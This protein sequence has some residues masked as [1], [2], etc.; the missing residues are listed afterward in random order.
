[1]IL[2][3]LGV[4]GCIEAITLM[5]LASAKQ[6]LANGEL[7]NAQ[8]ILKGL[9]DYWPSSEEARLLAANAARRMEA[10]DEAERH[11]KAYEAKYGT[12]EPFLLEKTLLRVQSQG[13]SPEDDQLLRE[14]LKP[15]HSSYW[16]R[17]N[18]VEVFEALTLGYRRV[19]QATATLHCANELLQIEP[20]HV[21]G[22]LARGW[23]LE[24]FTRM[25]EALA[26]YQKAAELDPQNIEARL[27]LGELLL[28]FNRPAEAVGHFEWLRAQRPDN[29]GVGFGLARCR[30]A[31]D[32]LD[33]AARILDELLERHDTHPLLLEARGHV[34]VC[35]NE[36]DEAVRFL[37]EAV[38]R[39]PYLRQANYELSQCLLRQGKTAEAQKYQEQVD[40]ID[41][42]TKRLGE[43]Y[44]VL[45]S[46]TH[47]AAQCHEAAVLS[48]RLGH[49]E[50]GMRWLEAAIRKD[51]ALV[52]AHALM[53]EVYERHGDRQRAEYHR[54]Q[55]ERK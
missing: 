20:D 21:K 25:S 38:D 55:A 12:T 24:R 1:M 54:R 17:S 13:P 2:I 48:L 27:S 28:N 52:E 14:E 4:W 41:A 31:L 42:D 51:P 30:M 36:M 40:R 35:Q 7:E 6:A 34:A 44:R 43:L 47:T 22:L 5:K 11:L 49:E 9:I 8:H 3:G 46:P 50:D 32:E 37:Q 16:P 18:E 33:D 39:A 23:A 53:A 45:S 15:N 10:Y 19:E 26:D 29:V